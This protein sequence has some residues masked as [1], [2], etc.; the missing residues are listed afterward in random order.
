MRAAGASLRAKVSALTLELEAYAGYNGV[1]WSC[2]EGGL[3]NP[4]RQTRKRKR[5]GQKKDNVTLRLIKLRV[6]GKILKQRVIFETLW[7][8]G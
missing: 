2:G 1:L 6:K 7:R 8:R 4:K 3:R 5:K